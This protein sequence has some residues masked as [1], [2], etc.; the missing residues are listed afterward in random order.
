MLLFSTFKFDYFDCIGQFPT[1]I[2]NL[3]TKLVS[4]LFRKSISI[5]QFLAIIKTLTIYLKSSIFSEV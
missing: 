4:K 2:F 1:L 5:C 3:T